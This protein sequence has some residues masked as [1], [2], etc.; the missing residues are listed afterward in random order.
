MTIQ[1][2][3]ERLD[4]ITKS[5][6]D[7]AVVVR[8]LAADFYKDMGEQPMWGEEE[9]YNAEEEYNEEEEA[10]MDK[11]GMYKDDGR[12]MPMP[13]EGM[14]DPM[15]PSP[16]E[17]DEFG[18]DDGGMRP[19]DQRL[20][21]EEEELPLDMMRSR[22][23]AKAKVAGKP[24]QKRRTNKGYAG[25]AQVRSDE[26]DSPF[27]EQQD[28]LEGNEPSPS[29]EMSGDRSDETFNM[30][31]MRD[32]RKQVVSLRK[33]LRGNMKVAKSTTPAPGRISKGRDAADANDGFMTREIQTEVKGRTYA[34]INALREQVGDLPRNAF[35]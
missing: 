16:L 23:T 32:L 9:E 4:L 12:P 8:D 33:E 26:E 2:T 31:F 35:V 18:M 7:L 15:S 5:L 34:E 30:N 21:E 28:N 17:E 11:G 1:N 14:G 6:G 19:E 24:V 29:G 3:D 20:P 22:R 25:V 27:G 10:L 13:E